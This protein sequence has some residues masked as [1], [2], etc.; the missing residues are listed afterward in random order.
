MVNLG[1]C[2]NVLIKLN[3][4]LVLLTKKELKTMKSCLFKQREYIF[5]QL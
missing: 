5:E 2:D 1:K 4:H 3:T